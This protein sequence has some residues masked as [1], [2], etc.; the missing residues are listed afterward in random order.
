[1]NNYIEVIHNILPL[2]T[3]IE[4][5]L[6]HVKKQISELRYE[7]ALGLLQDSML[8]V[9]SIEV[10]LQPMRGIS[11][12][13]IVPLTDIL[14]NNI[15]KVL[16]SYE[17]GKQELI[18]NQIEKEVLPAFNNWKKELEKTLKPYILS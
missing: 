16:E 12:G 5:G 14:K 4:E 13:K 7:E 10:A 17:K 6:T 8:G 18:E 1:M 9:A 3:T 2:L 15:N 11:M